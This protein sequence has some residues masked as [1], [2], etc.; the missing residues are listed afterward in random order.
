MDTLMRTLKLVVPLVV[1]LIL[2]TVL[3]AAAQTPPAPS[4]P[5]ERYFFNVSVGGQSREQTF[6]TNSTFTIYNEP[7]GAVA[8]AQAIG[9][10]TL[11][12]IGAGAH[13]WKNLGVGIS[14]STVKNKNDASSRVRVPHPIIFGQS[15]E[16]TAT[17]S[18][19]EHSENVVH[20][21]FL[22]TVPV[23]NKI[24]VSLMAG[25]SFFT[26][27]QDIATVRAPQD[28]VEGSGFTSVS[29]ATVTVTDVKDSPVGFNVG[30]DATYD[31][32]RIGRMV[33]GVGGFV[34][35]SQASLD[36]PLPDGITGDLSDLKAGG[37][38]AA[39]GLRLR[40]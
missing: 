37:G 13:V 4:A 10:G 9:G 36:L 16:A 6:E 29:I 15:R 2:G 39:A 28:I 38:Q 17:V 25:P 23:T 34:R 19:L 18:D 26:V 14:Y 12:D 27:R 5:T 21:Q 20:L 35:Y 7:G 32:T 3:D 8:T 24:Q 33:V 40:F 11:V 30:A 1:L 31:I 22:W